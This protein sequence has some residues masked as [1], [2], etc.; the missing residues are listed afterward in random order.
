[1]YDIIEA[2]TEAERVYGPGADDIALDI[3]VDIQAEIESLTEVA[4]S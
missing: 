2:I 1:M 3:P 4:Q